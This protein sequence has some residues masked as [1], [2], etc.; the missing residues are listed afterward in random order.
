MLQHTQPLRNI[1][2]RNPHIITVLITT[3]KPGH[4]R[5]DP[6][7]LAYQRLLDRRLHALDLRNHLL[8]QLRNRLRRLQIQLRI[9]ALLRSCE[10]CVSRRPPAA[11][12]AACPGAVGPVAGPDRL[13]GHGGALPLEPRGLG[14]EPRQVPLELLRRRQ[15][16]F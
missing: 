12:G 13:Q 16:G 2:A 8:R 6:T 4:S 3:L 7:P 9:R 11:A 10:A 5:L 14:S 1:Y 15:C